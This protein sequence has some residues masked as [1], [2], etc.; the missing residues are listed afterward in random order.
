MT[1]SAHEPRHT[2]VST[3]DAPRAIGPYSQAVSA[4]PM[5]FV[6]GQIPLD[7]ETGALVEGDVTAQARRVMRNLLAI[8]RAAGHA[9]TDIVRCTIFLKSMGDFAAVNA[10]Y[11]EALG[12]HRPSR[13]T[14]EVARLPRDVLVEI[15]CTCV[16]PT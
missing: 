15:D 8:V 4:G 3:P 5:T 2:I 1:D 10:V 16:R 13:A 12:D 11:A 9:P 6:S 14:V 7:P